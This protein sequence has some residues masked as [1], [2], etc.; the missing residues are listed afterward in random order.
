MEVERISFEKLELLLK[1]TTGKIYDLVINLARCK[2]LLQICRSIYISQTLKYS[3]FELLLCTYVFYVLLLFITF[4][5]ILYFVSIIV[6]SAAVSAVPCRPVHIHT[7]RRLS[8][9]NGFTFF[10]FFSNFSFQNRF[11][12]QLF[13]VPHSYPLLFSPSFLPFG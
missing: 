10:S 3:Y 7:V 1:V 13:L 8:L 11:P 9:L 2:Y 12:L 6:V 5:V 4:N